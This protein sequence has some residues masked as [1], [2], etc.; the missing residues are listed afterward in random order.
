VTWLGTSSGNPTVERNVSCTVVQAGS[1][2]FIVDCGE[3][4]HRQLQQANVD[5]SKI[6]WS[7]ILELLLPLLLLLLLLLSHSIHRCP[8]PPNIVQNHNCSSL[9]D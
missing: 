5:V 4:S 7:G 3:G 2:V 1:A 8:S 6:E 9:Q